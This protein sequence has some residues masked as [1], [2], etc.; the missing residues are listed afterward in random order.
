MKIEDLIAI[1]PEVV[2]ALRE[3]QGVVALESTIIAQ[4]LPYPKNIETALLAEE[5]IKKEQV[6]PATI[7]VLNGVIKVGLSSEEIK[8]LA[9]REKVRKLSRR[10]LAVCCSEQADGAMTVAATMAVAALSG[11][12]VF[13]TGGIGGAHRGSNLSF[14]ISA[15][16]YEFANSKVACVSAGAKAILDLNATLE[17]LETL[18]I[19]VMGFKTNYFPA[20][21]S[22][23]SDLKLDVNLDSVTE[24]AAMLKLYWQLNTQ[25]GALICNPIPLTAEIPQPK[26][27][28]II[29][30]A[31]AQAEK[32]NIR[33][34]E[35]TPFLL[36][37]INQ[38]L[39]G[40]ALLANQALYY[41]NVCLAAKIANEL[42]DQ[43]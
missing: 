18:G 1:S 29:Q 27:E 5:I 19:L 15:D 6:V 22:R 17:I 12:E 37:K 36:S 43:K 10:D 3:G 32:Q 8:Y 23:E 25:K 38:S 42:A 7:A 35:V 33:G 41:N 16:L 40:K 14:D 21:Y 2:N 31:L 34:K 30:M 24:I 26:I 4:G 9:Q 28:A 11:I 39:N 13:A 20:F